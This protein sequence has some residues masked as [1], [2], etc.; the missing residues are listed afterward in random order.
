[1]KWTLLTSPVEHEDDIVTVRQRVR[2]LAERL[3]FEVQDQTRIA[4]A[5]SE[6]AR[7]AYGYAGGGRVEYG[8]DQGVDGQFLAIRISDKG[9]A[10]P[11]SMPS[12]RAATA[13]PP[14]SASASQGRAG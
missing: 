11:T 12:C 1:V 7:N 2:R 3:G 10:S 13:R 5:V 8:L 9:R 6:I 14:G 4:T